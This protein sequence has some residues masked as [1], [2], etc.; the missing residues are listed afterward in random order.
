M[1]RRR[2]RTPPR[3]ARSPGG[4]GIFRKPWTPGNKT[5]IKKGPGP[6]ECSIPELKNHYFDC[7]SIHEADRFI[8]TN[9]AIIAY[10]GATYGGDIKATLENCE[11]FTFPEPDDPEDNYEDI[12]DEEDE[13]KIIKTAR[14]QLTYKEQK[15]FDYE[16]SAY[17]KR[18]EQLAK[19]MEQAFSIYLN[20]CSEYL[21]DKL[22]NTKKNGKQYHQLKMFWT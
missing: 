7:G 12:K 19:H 5:K 20:Q 4:R 9:K 2:P 6:A 13:N 21:Q 15:K 18:K 22:K 1:F 8:T 17:V 16:I 10:M 3:K 14:E 11:V